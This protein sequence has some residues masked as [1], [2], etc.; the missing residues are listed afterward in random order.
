MTPKEDKD[1]KLYY[2]IKEVAQLFG[3]NESTL[4]FWET[5][6]SEISPRKT[7]NGARYYTEEDIDNVRLIHHL[8]K[9]RGLTLAG[10]RR[11]LDEN[12]EVT[13]NHESIIHRLKKLQAELLILVNELDNIGRTDS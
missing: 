10:A 8:V 3:V 5:K 12:R 1:V 11:K 13:V 4:R 7:P 6:F 9:E 2:S